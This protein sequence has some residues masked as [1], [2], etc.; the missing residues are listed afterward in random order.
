MNR[1]IPYAIIILTTIYK[2]KLQILNRLDFI[3]VSE[4]RNVEVEFAS[5]SNFDFVR[6]AS[7]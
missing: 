3:L 5:R 4:H 6:K 7:V 2:I 1:Y